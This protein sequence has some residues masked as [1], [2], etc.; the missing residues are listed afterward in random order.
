MSDIEV[1]TRALAE[2]R[3]NREWRQFHTTKNLAV[4][5]S[6]EAAELNELFLWKTPEE[7]ENVDKIRIKEELADVLAFSFL[8]AEKHGFD[9]RDIILE[10][11]AK[12]ETKYPVEKSKGNALKYDQF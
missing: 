4:A 11:I 7:A 3:D 8:L 2:F 1:I 12:N 10:K 6:V 9:I 5:I